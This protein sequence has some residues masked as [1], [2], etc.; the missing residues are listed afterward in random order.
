LGVRAHVQQHVGTPDRMTLAQPGARA[1]LV[2]DFVEGAVRELR[3]VL[4][5]SLFERPPLAGQFVEGLDAAREFPD[6]DSETRGK[7]KAMANPPNDARP[8]FMARLGL[9]PPYTEED[10][11]QAYLEKAKTAHP[12]RGGSPA[13]FHEIQTAFEQARHYVQMRKDRRAWIASQMDAYVRVQSVVARLREQY[14]VE[15]GWDDLKWIEQSFGDFAH[16]VDR[17]VWI[18]LENSS[19]AD[20]M[21][22]D[23]VQHQ[24]A[25]LHLQRLE[26]SDCHVSE[27]SLLGLS[28]FESLSYLDLRGTPVTSQIVTLVDELR[29]LQTVELAGTSISWWSRMRVRSI[30]RRRQRRSLAKRALW[31]VGAGPQHPRTP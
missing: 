2:D 31:L 16:L 30:L 23:L 11:K 14:G 15:V 29:H 26:L 28:V 3:Q 27:A 22:R 13:A 17:V 9:L 10:V 7:C 19:A 4:V 25:L 1:D 5:P 6:I 8:T 24:S 20:E 12:D 21:I 18:R